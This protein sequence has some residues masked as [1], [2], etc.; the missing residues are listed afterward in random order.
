MLKPRLLPGSEA[1]DGLAGGR[2]QV[3][4]SHAVDALPVTPGRAHLKPSV[5]VGLLPK[6]WSSR[7]GS[8]PVD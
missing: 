6:I 4:S 7:N 2:G 3:P 5:R 1:S 8:P